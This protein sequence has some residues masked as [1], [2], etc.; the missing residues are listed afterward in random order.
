MRYKKYVIAG[1]RKVFDKYLKDNGHKSN[2]G[3]A[4]YLRTEEPLC[5]L[6]EGDTIVLLS[7]WWAKSW[8]KNALIEVKKVYSTINFEYLDGQFGEKE[9][10]RLISENILSRFDILDL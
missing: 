1:H 6:C 7:G 10:K 9:R 3:F 5:Q 2:D 8:A 4:F